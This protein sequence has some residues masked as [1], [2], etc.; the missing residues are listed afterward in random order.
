MFYCAFVLACDDKDKGGDGGACKSLPYKCIFWGVTYAYNLLPRHVC[1]ADNNATPF[2]LLPMCVC[3]SACESCFMRIYVD[4][5][6][7]GER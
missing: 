6:G 5:F 2:S 7:L 1:F 3:V 4:R